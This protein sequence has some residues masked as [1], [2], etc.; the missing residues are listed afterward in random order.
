M[1]EFRAVVGS[2]G[3]G[4]D[5]PDLQTEFAAAIHSRML[6]EISES[7]CYGFQGR[8]LFGLKV[9][10]DQ[11]C[12]FVERE[13]GPGPLEEHGQPIPKADQENDVNE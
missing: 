10:G 5:D 11:A 13:I 9:S 4:P 1:G 8:P 7:L 6:F 2:D 12:A 3:P